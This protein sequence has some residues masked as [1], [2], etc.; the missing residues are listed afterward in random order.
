MLQRFPNLKQ[1]PGPVRQ[2]PN[3]RPLLFSGRR[4]FCSRGNRI[5]ATNDD[6]RSFEPICTLQVS[7]SYRLAGASTLSR[8]VTR[9]DCFRMREV[10]GGKRAYVFRG[11]IYVQNSGSDVAVCTMRIP[12][13]SRPVSLA[14]N[15]QGHVVFGEYFANQARQEVHIY[16]SN[17]GG[18]NWDIVYTFEPGA[19]R[20]V[21]GIAYDRWDDCYWICTGDYDNENC[22]IRASC[23]FTD[24]RIL[25]QGG[26][27]NRFFTLQV[28]ENQIV[29]ATDT[30]LESNY[31]FVIDKDTGE[32]RQANAIENASFC[33][34]VVGNQ[35]FVSTNAERSPVNDNHHSHIWMGHQSLLHWDRILSRPVDVVDKIGRL[36]GLRNGFFQHPHF[37]FPEGTNPGHHLVCY[38]MGLQGQ[39]DA[40]MFHDVQHLVQ[41]EHVDLAKAA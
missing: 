41:E 13:G 16:G 33:T 20:H 15:S 1:L 30:P 35:V 12:R 18:M 10:T 36:P 22:L 37:A 4:L 23:D 31:V 6:G 40:L 21:H 11:G 26:Q 34:C 9:T 5:V 38:G 32:A 29:A 2:V 3:T 19:I 7:N 24:V 14:T 25:R 8:R 28:F 17:D 39:H 27:H